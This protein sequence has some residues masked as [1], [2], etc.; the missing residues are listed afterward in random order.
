M[1]CL[2]DLSLALPLDRT[3]ASLEGQ[4]DLTLVRRQWASEHGLRGDMRGGDPSASIFKRVSEP[5][6]NGFGR[7]AGDFSQTYKVSARRVVLTPEIHSH[8]EDA[9]RE[10]RATLDN[11]L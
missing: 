4:T 2:A 11:R 9:N 10:A 3:V 1:L 7:A 5:I 6:P 8:A